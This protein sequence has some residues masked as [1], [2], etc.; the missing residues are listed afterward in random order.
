MSTLEAAVQR[1]EATEANLQKL[2][3]LWDEISSLIPRGPA[4]GAPP[5]YDELCLAF[6]RILSALPAIDGVRL[7]NHLFEYDEIGQMRIDAL[8]LGEIESQVYVESAL[9]EQGKQ[10]REYRFHLNAKRRELVRDRL[11]TLINEGDEAL[12]IPGDVD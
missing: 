2:E 11:L 8:N 3:K 5:E 7:E 9:E 10:L 4:F 12:R 1:F 6:E